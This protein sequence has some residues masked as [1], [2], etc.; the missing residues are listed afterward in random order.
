MRETEMVRLDV[1]SPVE[2]RK[3]PLWLRVWLRWGLSVWG[4]LAMNLG[5]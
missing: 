4:S 2:A 5:V 3:K 1:V